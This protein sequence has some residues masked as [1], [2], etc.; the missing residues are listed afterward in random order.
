VAIGDAP[1]GLPRIRICGPRNTY[2]HTSS[3]HLPRANNWRLCTSPVGRVVPRQSPDWSA[4]TTIMG[5]KPGRGVKPGW[6][7]ESRTQLEL[8]PIMPLDLPVKVRSRELTVYP[9]S[10]I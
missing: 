10:H 2:C 5:V 1:L 9:R 6:G 8:Q 3:T 4:R 7:S